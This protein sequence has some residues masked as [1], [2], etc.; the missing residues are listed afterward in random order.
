MKDLTSKATFAGERV[1]FDRMMKR[2]IRTSD[3][4][5]KLEEI[6]AWEEEQERL[7]GRKIQDDLGSYQEYEQVKQ[8]SPEERREMMNANRKTEYEMKVEEVRKTFGIKDQKSS[9]IGGLGSGGYGAYGGRAGFG[10]AGNNRRRSSPALDYFTDWFEAVKFGRELSVL[11]IENNK[12]LLKDK[13]DNDNRSRRRT[14]TGMGRGPQNIVTE[15]KDQQGFRMML[16]DWKGYL[17]QY[18]VSAFTLG[19]SGLFTVFNWKLLFVVPSYYVAVASLISV[20]LS[21]NKLK[22]FNDGPFFKNFFG[23]DDNFRKAIKERKTE[24]KARKEAEEKE[25][26]END[27]RNRRRAG[28]SSQRTQ[29]TSTHRSHQVGRKSKAQMDQDE[30]LIR[31]LESDEPESQLQKGSEHETSVDRTNDTDEIEQ[32]SPVQVKP[33][34]TQNDEIIKDGPFVFEKHP[35]DPFDV[36]KSELNVQNKAELFEF[37]EEFLKYIARHRAEFSKLHRPSELLRLFAPLIPSFNKDFAGR[38]VVDRDSWTFKNICYV[39]GKTYAQ[40]DSGFER[41]GEHDPNFF[42]CVDEIIETGLFYKI[43][44][45][46]PRSI[47]KNR[48][49]KNSGVLISNLRQTEKD[50]VDINAELPNQDGFIKIFKITTNDEGQSFLPL[51][52]SGDVLRFNGMKANGTKTGIIEALDKPSDLSIL[53]GLT[54]AEDALIFDIAGK[55][56]TAIAVNGFTGSG[57][58]ASTGS[59][60]A[61]MLITHGPDELGVILLD[62]KDGSFWANFKYAPHVLGYF[63][64]E[65]MDKYPAIMAVLNK[66]V[67]DRQKQLNEGVRMK[68]YFEAR[69]FFKKK[70][71]WERLKDVPRLIVVAD[72]QLA[73]LSGLGNLDASRAQQ[74]K[75]LSRDEKKFAGFLDSYNSQIGALANVVREGGITLMALSQRT[76]AKSFPRSL[77]AASSI[78][79]LMKAQFQSDAERLMPGATIP[80][81]SNL[82][83]GSGYLLA[84]G[85]NLSQLTTPLY[86]GNPGY[87][88]EMVRI[89]SL[90]WVIIEDYKQ[91]L[92]K[93]PKGYFLSKASQESLNT[94][95]EQGLTPFNL[96][97]R[98][99]IFSEAKE[100]LKDGENR[101][102]FD[103]EFPAK[104]FSIDL[105]Q[106]RLEEQSESSQSR[107]VQTEAIKVQSTDDNHNQDV[108]EQVDSE[109]TVIDQDILDQVVQSQD[110]SVSVMSERDVQESTQ[111]EITGNYDN[112]TLDQLLALANNKSEPEETNQRELD[113]KDVQQRRVIQSGSLDQINEQKDTKSTQTVRP[114]IRTVKP[115]QVIPNRAVQR[116]TNGQ[117]GN[118]SNLQYNKFDKDDL[119]VNDLRAY[120]INHDKTTMAISELSKVFNDNTIKSAIDQSIISIN[121]SEGTVS[122]I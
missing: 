15:S 18:Q 57:K 122:L 110:E 91:D 55:E 106:L 63:G 59:W 47:D 9:S 22:Q 89:V 98:D 75:N 58:T 103:P 104:G 50:V 34:I 85:L 27:P 94:F 93:E 115:K 54:N 13:T 48:F 84:N 88:E 79:F 53:F 8:I 82:P 16:E 26:E 107:P 121:L 56:N 83:V 4:N 32:I 80:D 119:T 52:S 1:E 70:N 44:V 12:K 49:K 6:K 72:E 45:R 35:K 11:E 42:F 74:N 37:E 111:D 77:L 105:D 73:L 68:N 114:V 65:D 24:E 78:K 5:D 14:G 38:T 7:K 76:D 17:Y 69:K 95:K 23:S 33:T 101:L 36:P 120:L 64:R 62:P 117:I 10:Q 81:V 67:K 21:A 90:A 25:A 31:S 41:A 40:I 108:F 19:L 112:L 43:K 20:G 87:L 66:L 71:D 116:T 61:N 102:H 100:I 3:W 92:S 29:S 51:V 99:V 46:L 30:D 109:G 2:V 60:L 113:Q 97:N 96:F 39:L 28:R 118:Q 86:S